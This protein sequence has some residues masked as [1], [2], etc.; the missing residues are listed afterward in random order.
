MLLNGFRLPEK[1]TDKKTD[2]PLSL[3]VLSITQLKQLSDDYHNS[4]PTLAAT[5]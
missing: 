2:K 5:P 4:K 1:K 3:S